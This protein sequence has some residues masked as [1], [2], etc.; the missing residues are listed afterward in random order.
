MIKNLLCFCGLLTL[1]FSACSKFDDVSNAEVLDGDP[2]FAI[3]LASATTSFQELIENFDDN[4]FITIDADGLI[5]LRYEGDVSLRTSQEILEEAVASLPPF[6]PLSQTNPDTLPFNSPEELE[7]DSAIL[8]I[9]SLIG[10]TGT[11]DSNMPSIASVK[12][13]LPQARLNGQPLVLEKTF[14]AGLS[15]LGFGPIDIG[16]YSLVPEDGKLNVLYEAYDEN[17]DEVIF[18]EDGYAMVIT[19]EDFFFTYI[20]GYLGYRIHDGE[21]DTIAID[22]FENWIQGEVYFEDP[23]I[24]INLENSF[25]IPT[26]SVINIFDIYTASGEVLPL[27]SDVLNIADNQGIDFLYPTSNQVGEVLTQ[28]F[29]FDKDNSNIRE[30]LGSQP[31]ALDYDVDART[32]PDSLLNIRGFLTDESYYK[33]QV[34]VELPMYGWARGFVAT[35]TFDIDFSEYN[36][37]K[38]VEFKLVSDNGTPLD[39]ATQVYF[40]DADDKV[41]DSLLTMQESLIAAAPVNSEGIV[42]APFSKSTLI[43]YSAERFDGIRDAKKATTQTAFSTVNNGAISVK[44][45]AEDEVSIRMGMK[46]KTQ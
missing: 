1:L 33:V 16:G 27:Q 17:G 46:L 3:P 42:E 24:R 14:P 44:V 28:T 13:T 43:P 37:I 45:F 6:L 4:T 12:V 23:E 26:R 35:D 11:Q 5:R 9:G 15:I 21:R 8:R 20:D 7:V 18:G 22:F 41:L 31:V 34:E 32:N 36:N 2:E 38:E 29:V 30:V 10:L 39:I 19:L 40:L 25:G